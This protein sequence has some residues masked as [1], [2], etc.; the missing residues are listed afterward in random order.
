MAIKKNTRQRTAN[1]GV[2]ENEEE[3]DERSRTKKK[4][5]YLNIQ[6]QCDRGALLSCYH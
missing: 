4:I 6:N 3:E 1:T 5:G 2:A